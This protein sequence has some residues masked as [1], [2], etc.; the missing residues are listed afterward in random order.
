MLHP[1]VPVASGQACG[2]RSWRLPSLRSGHVLAGDER[3]PP[4]QGRIGGCAFGVPDVCGEPRRSTPEECGSILPCA[5]ASSTPAIGGWLRAQRPATRRDPKTPQAQS[6]LNQLALP[7]PRAPPGIER[8]TAWDPGADP[9]S[10][11]NGRPGSR[12]ARHRPT[13]PEV[14][15]GMTDARPRRSGQAGSARQGGGPPSLSRILGAPRDNG[16]EGD[17][18]S[19]LQAREEV[20]G[21]SDAREGRAKPAWAHPRLRHGTSWPGSAPDAGTTSIQS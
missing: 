11:S 5:P 14:R 12:L 21:T 17:L 9:A 18:P 16:R 20:R 8:R 1:D 3:V 4:P 10:G 13:S 2:F 6:A 7:Q 15:P 19:G